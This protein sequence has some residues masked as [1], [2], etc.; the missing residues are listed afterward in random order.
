MKL[1]VQSELRGPADK[2][3]EFIDRDRAA[4]S[5][6]AGE[7]LTVGLATETAFRTP[8]HALDF[9]VFVGD[10]A[11][12]SPSPVATEEVRALFKTQRDKV[13][14]FFRYDGANKRYDMHY[15]KKGTVGDAAPD[16]IAAQL[17]AAPGLVGYFGNMFKKP[18]LYHRFRDLVSI[19]SGSSPWASI[20]TL[21]LAD[22]AGFAV[23]DATG[24]PENNNVQDVN[25][26][27]G[28]MSAPIINM[29]V[30]HSLSI[31]ELERAKGGI[32]PFGSQMIEQKK[33]Y[34]T[35]ALEML[36]GVLGYFGNPATG[37]DGLFDVNPIVPW[38]GDSV[39]N[40]W[41]DPAETTKGSKIYQNLARIVV[42]FLSRT[43]N[44][45][46]KLR[47]AMAPECYNIFSTAP[48]S[49]VYN[50]T[51][52]L[53]IMVANMMPGEMKDGKIPDFEFFPDP[54]LAA[55]TIFNPNE[56]D[57]L[58]ITAPETKAGPDETTQP[59]V[60]A[61]M[62]LDEFVY[63]VIP[64]QYNTQYKILRRYA[65]VFAPVPDA[66]EVISGFGFQPSDT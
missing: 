21:Y 46:P 41:N 57:Y 37:T 50:P 28:I 40:I 25:A 23:L 20:M 12:I 31:E 16:L 52:A 53:K 17:L 30:S 65:G 36:L 39:H 3:A 13:L 10:A 2:V 43:Y 49:D 51:A 22:Y 45:F 59:L 18:L 60:L 44:K 48:Y 47:I 5:I 35:Y 64:G 38:L 4:R 42:E 56:Y 54:L 9:P 27:A 14:E 7:E 34:A 1:N 62:P 11:H 19:Q 33:S 6:L 29:S 66:I 58:V 32:M 8:L 15:A 55:G 61:G 24:S 26:Q 63:P